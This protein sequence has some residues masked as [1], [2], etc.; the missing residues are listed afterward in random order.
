MICWARELYRMRRD[1]KWHRY[2]PLPL[3]GR[4][5]ILLAEVE[6]DPTRIFWS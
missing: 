6:R 3:A 5:D 4:F 2:E 1:L